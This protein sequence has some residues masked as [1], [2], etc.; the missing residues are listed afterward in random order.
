[1]EISV[2][3]ALAI[4]GIVVTVVGFFV[5]LR[6][7]VQAN[8]KILE[9][10]EER[11]IADEVQNQQVLTKLTGAIEGMERTSR[12]LHNLITQVMLKN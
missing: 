3:L 11:Q 1:M 2:D 5:N 10:I 12:D 8:R 7:N 9:R 4:G 6:T